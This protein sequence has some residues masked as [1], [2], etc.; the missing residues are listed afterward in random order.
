MVS[1]VGQPSGECTDNERQQ[2]YHSGADSQQRTGWGIWGGRT[3]KGTS[4]ALADDEDVPCIFEGRVGLAEG[5]G[6]GDLGPWLGSPGNQ[7]DECAPRVERFVDALRDLV[8][9]VLPAGLQLVEIR[10][11]MNRRAGQFLQGEAAFRGGWS[12][13][14]RRAGLSSTTDS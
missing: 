13:K 8:R 14:P 1:Q 7:C 11:V 10:L 4:S 2:Q 5:A 12:R 9:G 6:G 3:Y